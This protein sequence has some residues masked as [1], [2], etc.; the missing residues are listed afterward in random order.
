MDSELREANQKLKMNMMSSIATM[1]P[2]ESLKQ[3]QEENMMLKQQLSRSMTSLISTGK[4]SIGWIQLLIFLYFL[5]Q[6]S[7]TSADKGDI[8]LVVWSDEHNNYQVYHEVRN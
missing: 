2:A 6:V 7:V 4:V 1:D 8:V 3:L 5:S